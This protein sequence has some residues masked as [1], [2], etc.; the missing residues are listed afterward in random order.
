MKYQPNWIL[1][2]IIFV[3]NNEKLA[4]PKVTFNNIKKKQ[5]T[6]DTQHYTND[7]NQFP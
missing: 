1:H 5:K 4:I 6:D 7:K 2:S 3:I